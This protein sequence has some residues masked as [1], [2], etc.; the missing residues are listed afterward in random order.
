MV[1]RRFV[2]PTRIQ[3]VVR[4][5]GLKGEMLEEDSVM[6]SYNGKGNPVSMTRT[7]VGTGRR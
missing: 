2:S 7:R 3:P 6:I 1:A 4:S 5:L